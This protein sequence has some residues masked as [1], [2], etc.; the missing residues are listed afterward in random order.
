MNLVFMK[1]G[2]LITPTDFV[3][4]ILKVESRGLHNLK[5]IRLDL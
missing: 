4:A 1:W 3:V 5:Q 2:A